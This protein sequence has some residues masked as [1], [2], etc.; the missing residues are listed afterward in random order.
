MTGRRRQQ[1]S[2]RRKDRDLAM[3]FL[4][5]AVAVGYLTAMA[6]IVSAQ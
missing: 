3:V 6:I 2:Q 5:G 1:R 4:I